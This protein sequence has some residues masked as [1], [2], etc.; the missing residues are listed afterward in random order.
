MPTAKR[1]TV[2]VLATL[3]AALVLAGGCQT[4]GEQR[5]AIANDSF[6]TTLDVLT[7]A[8]KA[9]KIDDATQTNVIAPARRT[10]NSLLDLAYVAAERGEGLRL[11][12]ILAEIDR[13]LTP[14]LLRRFAIQREAKQ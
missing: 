2:V 11:H 10:I 14:L 12:Q 8:R 4:S 1:S 13:E 5:L 3:L 7:E 6:A 9:R